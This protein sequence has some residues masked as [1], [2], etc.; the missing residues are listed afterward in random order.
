M[1]NGPLAIID[2]GSNG[3]RFGIVTNLQRHL[4]VT[5][6]ER[7]SISLLEEQGD[8]KVI[9]DIII[10]Q[11][12]HAFLRFKALC[13]QA[14]VPPE[15]IHVLATEATRVAANAT[16][17]I[18]RIFDATGWTVRLLSK[19]EE[20]LISAS[21]IVGTCYEVHGLTTDCGGGS[22][23]LSYVMTLTDDDH[24]VEVSETPVSLPFGSVVMK[25]RLD[26]CKSDADLQAL[27]GELVQA[28]KDAIV[29]VAPPDS[30]KFGNRGFDLYMSGGSF[31]ALGYLSMAKRKSK[32]K[33]QYPLPMI[34]GYSLSNKALSKLVLQYRNGDPD[35]IKGFR[36]T[37]RR[38]KMMPAVCLLVIAMLEAL[39]I[40]R[41]HFSEGGVRQGL[42]YQMLPPEERAKDPLLCA[43][44]ALRER[45]HRPTTPNHEVI[46]KLMISA[47]PAVYLRHDHPLQLHRILPAA[48]SLAPITSAYPKESRAVFAL[49]LT[50]ASGPLANAPGLTHKQRAMLSLILA[51]AQG[52]AVHDPSLYSLQHVAGK[53]ALALAKYIGHL[54]ELIYIVSPA[55]P[56]V[57]LIETGMKFST[58]RAN[59]D[60]DDSSMYS[61]GSVS[62]LSMESGDDLTD[63]A[64]DD[65]DTGNSSSQELQEIDMFPPVNL[66]IKIPPLA[67][68]PLLNSPVIVSLLE[69][70]NQKINKTKND[71]VSIKRTNICNVNLVPTFNDD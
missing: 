43:A 45:L 49:H 61:S 31:R 16:A 24:P 47:L 64:A 44:M 26:E 29:Q 40:H 8:S 25:R 51:Y 20:A 56:G 69:N 19:Q 9:P 34:N 53:K 50:L 59:L 62:S 63:W 39:P 70:L 57:G 15:N 12:V 7:V 27:Y 10:E 37:K 68:H 5:F 42:C 58:N 23:E 71:A 55:N 54:L 6:E 2:M 1:A 28:F 38:A 65:D 13:E 67:S 52:G 35:D 32:T 36:I 41:V 21:G 3:I 22:V 48:V 46:H 11:V 60:V 14:S 66:S 18:D 33:T 17:F 4:P 30:L